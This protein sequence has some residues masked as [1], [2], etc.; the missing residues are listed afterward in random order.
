MDCKSRYRTHISKF[1][2]IKYKNSTTLAEY[3]HTLRESN[4]K[5]D[6]EWSIITN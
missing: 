3:I 4:I 2:Q 5:F 1:S 6:I